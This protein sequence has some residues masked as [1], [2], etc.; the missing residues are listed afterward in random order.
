MRLLFAIAHYYHHEPGRKY[1]SMQAD[2]TP[3]II[4][5]AQAITMLHANSGSKSAV[6]AWD[7]AEP[8]PLQQAYTVDV[9][10][11]THPARH[12]L[13]SLPV[14]RASYMHVI[15]EDDPAYLPWA[16]QRF[17][18]S[19]VESYDGFGYLDDDQWFADGTWLE[20]ALA[21]VEAIGEDAVL[22]PQ[23]F[24][25]DMTR[26]VPKMYIA[27]E[28]HAWQEDH[29]AQWQDRKDRQEVI[30]PYQGQ[31]VRCVR[32]S[33]PHAAFYFVTQAQ[34]QHWRKQPS[35]GRDTDAYVSPRVSGA[36]LSLM[37]TFRVYKPAWEWASF[38][39]I[40]HAYSRYL[41]KVS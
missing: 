38:Y 33:N 13:A 36:T 28:K 31:Q 17:L 10:I 25:L 15:S 22:Q 1:G 27:G 41:R 9:A 6:F 39:E 21:F 29:T 14:P 5:L 30:F 20:K 7:H 37:Q 19:Q 40:Q 16:C 2:P 34:M 23:Q 35:F 8:A 32:P 4:A 3:R 11:V 24:E 26:P 12:V 18:G